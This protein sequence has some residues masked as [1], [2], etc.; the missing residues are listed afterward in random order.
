MAVAVPE[1]FDDITLDWLQTALDE[2]GVLDVDLASV[3]V[4]PMH[5]SKGLIGDLATLHL[6]YQS[7]SGP[8]SLVLKLPAASPDSRQIGEMLGA[9]RREVAFYRHVAPLATTTQLPTCFYAGEDEAERRWALVLEA[10]DAD[11]FDYFAGATAGQATAAI[12]ALADFHALWWQSPT[13]FE[14][15][16]GFDVAGVG[17]L[18][19]AWLHNLPTFVDRYRDSLP[20]A[21]ADWV[22]DFAP[23]LSEW[24]ARAATEPLTMVHS[25][26]RL[27]NLLFEGDKVTMI[28][29]QTAMRAPAAMDVSCFIATSLSVENRRRDETALIDRYLTRI[30]THGVTVDAD[31]FLRSYDENLL[32]WMGQFGNNLAHLRPDDEATQ[33]GLTTMVERVY[34]T[35][36][37]RNVGRLLAS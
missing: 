13:S 27:D 25:D 6:T 33:A 16:P 34:T 32:W 21:T 24:S 28:D 4:E 30:G 26:Y 35:G 20:G 19:G 23:R 7:G 1:S 36:L 31:W 9:Y 2:G 8:A 18:Q 11:E 3:H 12:D 14:W 15:M 37:D 17:G 29:W 5:P 10:I 22:L